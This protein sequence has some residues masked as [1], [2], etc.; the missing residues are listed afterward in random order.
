MPD[1]TQERDTK[2]TTQTEEEDL[3]AQLAYETLKKRR[4]AKKRKR[5][6]IIAIVVVVVL[7]A[8]IFNIA[9]QANKTNGEDAGSQ[10]VTTAV[11]RGD[12]STTVSANGATEPVNSTVVTPEVDGII[13]D[14]QN[15]G[16]TT[17][18]CSL[19]C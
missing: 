9:G 3:E 14:L 11:Y 2:T 13:E 16:P 15:N 1:V 8:I 10:V 7:V 17:G 19:R 4:E 18:R 6:I 12:F 5:A